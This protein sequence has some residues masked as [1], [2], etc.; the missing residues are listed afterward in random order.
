MSVYTFD[1]VASDVAAAIAHEGDIDATSDPTVTQVTTWIEEYC[2]EVGRALRRQGVTP[3][4]ITATA[5][6]DLYEA[7]R[8][9]VS[10]RVATEWRMANQRTMNEYDAGKIAQWLAFLDEL[11][12]VPAS[13]SETGASTGMDHTFA[14]NDDRGVRTYWRRG[15]SFN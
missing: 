9:K 15:S 1:L 8:S 5:D 6:D 10:A 2:G 14:D 7:I 3:T 12:T 11:K 13:L 4:V